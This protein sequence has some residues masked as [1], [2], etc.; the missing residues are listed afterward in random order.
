[1]RVPRISSRLRPSSP[2]Q[3]PRPPAHARCGADRAAPC[4][5]PPP[6]PPHTHTHTHTHRPPPAARSSWTRRGSRPPRTSPSRCGCPRSI[7]ATRRSPA[8]P[9]SRRGTAAPPGAC[10]VAPRRRSTV[11]TPSPRWSILTKSRSTSACLAALPQRVHAPAARVGATQTTVPGR[12]SRRSPLRPASRSQGLAPPPPPP[13][14]LAAGTILDEAR[15]LRD[16]LED[17]E[18]DYSDDVVWAAV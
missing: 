6:P 10:W 2:S 14:P 18:R 8:T 3:A 16:I 5:P 9:T 15:S 7:T 12:C 17:D 11:H 1:M 4:P 13:P